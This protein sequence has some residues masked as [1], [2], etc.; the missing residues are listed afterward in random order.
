MFFLQVCS[1]VKGYN[2]TIC[3]NL[4]APEY[5][6]VQNEVQIFKNNFGIKDHMLASWPTFIY[7]FFAGALSDRFGRK[8]LI[9]LPILG[10]LLST[11]FQLIHYA[12]IR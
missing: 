3:D 7:A 9:C 8:W 6:D 10:V 4:T 1:V 5:D 11:I 2:D 12:F